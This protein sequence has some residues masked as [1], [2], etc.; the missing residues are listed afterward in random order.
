MWVKW[1]LLWMVR[2]ALRHS[3]WC[4]IPRTWAHG[5]LCWV[6]VLSCRKVKTNRNSSQK[7]QI[8]KEKSFYRYV[9]EL[10]PDCF[11]V[12]YGHSLKYIRTRW[13][14]TFGVQGATL[15]HLSIQQLC[16]VPEIMTPL[17]KINHRPCCGEFHV[18]AIFYL[19]HWTKGKHI[20]THL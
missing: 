14:F 18:G 1:P 13:H 11:G 15:T 10:Y 4:W 7:F 3:P 16:L 19:Y 17:H 6:A 8:L 20:S 5:Q 2:A 9:G 12:E